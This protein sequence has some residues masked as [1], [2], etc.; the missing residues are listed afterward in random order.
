[1]T[2]DTTSFLEKNKDFVVPEQVQL[3]EKSS[4]A[5]IKHLIPKQQPGIILI[6][7][8]MSLINNIFL[9]AGGAK[10]KSNYQFLSVASQFR[11]SLASLMTSIHQTQPNC[12][13][14]HFIYFTIIFIARR[15]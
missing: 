7:N 13:N 10:G 12:I 11:D 2:Y 15:Y 14:H 3:L 6:T 8:N 1:M 4:L 5:F 9:A